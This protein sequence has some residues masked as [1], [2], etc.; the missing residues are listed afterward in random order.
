MDEKS[1]SK[2]GKVL[3]FLGL[4][5]GLIALIIGLVVYIIAVQTATTTGG[6]MSIAI[7]WTLFSAVGL[8]LSFFGINKAR[9]AGKKSRISMTGFIL[10]ILSIC[11][12][13]LMIYSVHDEQQQP[14]PAFISYDGLNHAK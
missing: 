13:I 6:G 2:S 9:S 5:I 7:W 11:L 4:L 8:T 14:H 10:G 12:S 3:G 1:A